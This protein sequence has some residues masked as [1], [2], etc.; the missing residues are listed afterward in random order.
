MAKG[1]P[2]QMKKQN[3]SLVWLKTDPEMARKEPKNFF[4]VTS[5]GWVVTEA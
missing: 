4:P 1:N 5:H 2:M 3:N